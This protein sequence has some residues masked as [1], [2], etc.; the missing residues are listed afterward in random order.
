MKKTPRLSGLGVFLLAQSGAGSR[1]A[2]LYI[3][4]VAGSDVPSLRSIALGAQYK[5]LLSRVLGRST[6]FADC[7]ST[8]W[9]NI[10]AN[11]GSLLARFAALLDINGLASNLHRIDAAR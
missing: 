3:D 7:E 2:W 5:L 6:C 4:Y 11:T 8:A 9:A 1:T 10:R